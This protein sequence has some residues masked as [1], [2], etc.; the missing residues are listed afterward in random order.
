MLETRDLQIILNWKISLPIYRHQYYAKQDFSSK[1]IN[2]LK[3]VNFR[4][5]HDLVTNRTLDTTSNILNIDA[6]ILELLIHNFEFNF[7]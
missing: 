2:R 7:S 1:V 5:N 6:N 4:M 3:S